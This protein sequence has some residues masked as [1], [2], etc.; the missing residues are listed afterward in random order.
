MLVEW[1]RAPLEKVTDLYTRLDE[2][3][4]S[5]FSELDH[6]GY[7]P[8]SCYWGTWSEGHGQQIEWP[9]GN[10]HKIFGY[11]E[12]VS[13][14][15][16]VVGLPS[17]G[18][19]RLSS[20]G[21]R[22]IDNFGI[23]IVARLFGSPCSRSNWN[24]PAGSAIWQFST[25]HTERPPRC[26]WRANRFCKFPCTWSSNSPP[27]T[28]PRWALGLGADCSRGAQVV[29]QL[30]VMLENHSYRDAASRFAKRYADFDRHRQI[31]RLPNR[32][33]EILRN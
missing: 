24:T 6:F 2:T 21:R 11:L 20:T 10:G 1:G 5:T 19:C 18:G 23:V 30:D 15:A 4:L 27:T 33:A 3:I 14:S 16:C 12:A 29:N 31:D 17:A 7:R 28:L 32:V 8:D 26:F 9:S 25:A 13:R 22:S